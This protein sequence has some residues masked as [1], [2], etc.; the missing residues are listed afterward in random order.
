MMT[1]P[2]HRFLVSWCLVANPKPP[3]TC[4]NVEVVHLVILDLV[5]VDLFVPSYVDDFNDARATIRK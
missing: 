2:F 1:T 4:N 5:A 3:L